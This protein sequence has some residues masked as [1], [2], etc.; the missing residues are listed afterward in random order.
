MG[1]VHG[2][3]RTGIAGSVPLGLLWRSGEQWDGGPLFRG[4]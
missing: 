2:K 1:R 4:R 3:N